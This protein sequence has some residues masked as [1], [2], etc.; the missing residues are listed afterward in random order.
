MFHLKQS[1]IAN[2]LHSVCQVLN[3][4]WQRTVRSKTLVIGV[5][6]SK[7]YFITHS[8]ICCRNNCVLEKCHVHIKSQ[9]LNSVSSEGLFSL[10]F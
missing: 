4:F 10:L 5:K 7:T 9:K 3:N 1:T 8:I 6:S 2:E